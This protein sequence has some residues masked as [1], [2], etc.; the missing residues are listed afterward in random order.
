MNDPKQDDPLKELEARL[1]KARGERPVDAEQAE[2]DEL[3][4]NALGMAFRIGIELVVALVIGAGGGL[5]L[6][7]WLGTAPWLLILGL[8][9][10]MGAGIMNV[11]RAVSGLDYAPG[12]R[13]PG[14]TAT[15]DRQE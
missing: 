15:K 12:Y 1:R 7:R 11:Y 2:S 14:E 13:R 10:G 3:S 8:F 9:L 4:R 5:M 6:D